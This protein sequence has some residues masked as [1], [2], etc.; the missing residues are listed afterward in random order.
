MKSTILRLL[1]IMALSILLTATYSCKSKK[2]AA[3]AEA[4]RQRIEQMEAERQAQLAEEERRRAEEEERKERER[5]AAERAAER[6]PYEQL[7]RYFTSIANAT[8]EVAADNTISEAL[9]MF[10][11][12]EAP[13]LIIIYE[14]EQ[15][16]VVDY[17]EPTTIA[18]YLHYLKIVNRKP[19]N[20]ENIKFNEN[21]KIT[22][23]ILKKNF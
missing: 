4:E 17:D 1:G 3:E 6:A 2:K 14:N 19:D 5:I 9:N 18:K 8:S 20:I 23:L 7:N 11:S 10:A 13:V 12:Q 22:E 16:N 15:E 21:G